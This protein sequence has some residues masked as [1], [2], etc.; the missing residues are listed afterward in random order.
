MEIVRLLLVFVHLLGMATL[1]AAFLVQRTA[2]HGPLAGVWLVGAAVQLVS[3][4]TLVGLAP[5]TGAEY[6]D[7]KNGVKLLVLLVIAGLVVA[8]RNRRHIPRRLPVALG[9][10][11]LLNVALAVFWT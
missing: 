8:Y 2:P 7:I 9:A 3:G 1:V 4:V 10:L 5:L 11:V 6:D